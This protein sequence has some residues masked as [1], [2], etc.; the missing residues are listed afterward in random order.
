MAIDFEKYAKYSRPAPR[1]TSYPTANEFHEG[2][3]AGDLAAAIERSN[4][5]GRDLSLYFHLP[6]CRSACYFCGCNVIYTSKDEAKERYIDYLDREIKVA[7]QTL[8]TA[9]PVR[10][11]HF[12]G[13]TPTFFSAAQLTAIIKIIKKHFKKIAKD[14][15]FSVEIDPRFFNEDHMKALQEGS[16]NRV[17]FG[18]QDFDAQV[19]EAVH[20]VQSFDETARA[21]KIARSHG[22]KSVNIDLIYGLPFQTIESFTRTIALALSLAPDRVALFNYAHVPWI[23]KTMR[24]LD[25]T[26][27]PKPETKLKMLQSAIET[28]ESGGLEMIGMDHFASPKDELNIALKNGKLHRNFQG[29]TTHNECDLFGFGVT[30]ISEG[31]DFYAQNFRDLASYEAAIDAG[32]APLMRGIR[33]GEEDLLRKKIIGELMSNFALDFAAIS[34]EFKINFREKF[35]EEIAALAPFAEENLLTIGENSIAIAPTGRLLIRNIAII[36]DE[37][38]QKTEEVKRQFSKSV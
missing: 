20:R 19:Q 34:K 15:E 9:R 33:L 10:Q 13:G 6:F 14:A 24:K 37:F 21:V 29:Y 22:I 16:V 32:K 28:L 12:G 26:T 31:R 7:A 30:S 1:Y 2:F 4:A 11:L 36:F 8:N 3:E 17:S 25:E 23:K 5:S 27:L 35:G 18:A 38:L